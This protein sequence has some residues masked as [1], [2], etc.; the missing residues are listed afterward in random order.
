MSVF[1]VD[2]QGARVRENGAFVRID[3]V[4]EIRQGN[5]VGLLMV[6]GEVP[7]NTRIGLAWFGDPKT[8]ANALL[9]K[10]TP[11][12]ILAAKLRKKID[13]R[14][15]VVEVIDLVLTDSP[16]IQDAVAVDYTARVSVDN[17]RQSLLIKD[18]ISAGG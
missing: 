10:D 11:P 6:R 17:L 15:G 4:E 1:K 16:T 13:S 14:K 2:S 12:E 9:G 7:T 18:S 3:G 8:G 5:Q